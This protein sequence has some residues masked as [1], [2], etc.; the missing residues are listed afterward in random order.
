MKFYFVIVLLLIVSAFSWMYFSLGNPTLISY[1][2]S[3]K[4]EPHEYDGKTKISSIDLLVLYF[5]PKNK[6]PFTDEEFHKVILDVSSDLVLFHKIQL[7]NRSK[8]NLDVHLDPIIGQSDS[9]VY[10]TD[11]T[12]YGNPHALISILDEIKKRISDGDL[13]YLTKGNKNS[14]TIYIVYEGVG[15]SGSKDGAILSR[16]FLTKDEYLKVRSS[17]FAHEFYHTIG[18]PDGYDQ[19]DLSFTSDIM[20]LGRRRPIQANYL[21]SEVLSHFGI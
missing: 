5:V 20:G 3:K 2:I 17:L 7:N 19:N 9:F 14:P 4:T 1:N 16:S 15:A 18:V 8:I 21:S 12:G 13:A 10:D 6:K 11:D